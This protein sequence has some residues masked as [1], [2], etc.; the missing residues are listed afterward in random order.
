MT[1]PR[2]AT[3]G[4]ALIDLVVLPDGHLL[5]CL[6]GAV[7]NLSRALARQNVA[8][9]YLNPLSQDRFGRMLEQQLRH[10]G[11]LL[12]HQQAIPQPTS[13]AIVA[14]DALGK[15]SYS[16][17]RDGVA[18]R[19]INASDLI[20]LT[21]AAASVEVIATGCLALAPED[22]HIYHS[23]LASSRASG[24]AIVIDVNLRP[25]VIS[26]ATA[27]RRSVLKALAYADLLKASDEDLEFLFN[28]LG[29]PM[30]AARALLELSPAS[31]IAL[32]LGSRGAYLIA[33]SGL[34]WHGQDLAALKITDTVGAGDCFLAGLVTSMMGASKEA[35]LLLSATSHV[36]SPLGLSD[37]QASA[38]LTSAIAS[39]SHCIEQVGCE[40]PTKQQVITRIAQNTIKIQAFALGQTPE[41]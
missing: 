26:D 35:N 20:T 30:Q 38:A 3:A 31:W 16:F 8:T 23:W 25:A 19:H 32:T 24:K 27:Y 9:T 18:D 22:Q 21:E 39:A 41:H 5:P 34:T 17:Y 29:D 1:N 6:G 15:P 33:R 36:R 40:P 4:E 28:G 7:Y 11:A 13:L 14:V 37:G 10:A 12:A 2:I